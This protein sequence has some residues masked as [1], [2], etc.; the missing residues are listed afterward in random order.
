[1]DTRP[2]S[3][4]QRHPSS[5]VSRTNPPPLPVE[6]AFRGLLQWRKLLISSFLVS[7]LV[8]LAAAHFLQSRK[9]TC[10]GALL[11]SPNEITAPYYRPPLLGNL[12]H[13]INSPAF[14]EQLR[15][16]CKLED[17]L[18]DLRRNVTVELVPSGETLIVRFVRP[19]S[20]E[21]KHVLNTAMLLFVEQTRQISKQALE[22]FVREF[23]SNLDSAQLAVDNANTQLQVF[24]DS[25]EIKNVNS[26]EESATASQ[27]SLAE[28]D[29]ELEMARIEL[30]SATAKRNRLLSMQSQRAEEGDEH[31]KEIAT[32]SLPPVVGDND[33]RQ[34][35]RDQITREQESSSYAVKLNVKERE[36]QRAQKL[37]SQGLISD[38]EM[39]RIDGELSILQAEQNARVSQLQEQLSRIDQK[40]AQRLGDRPGQQAE[41][42]VTLAG[43]VEQPQLLEQSISLLEL[44]ILG[45]EHK[46]KGLA[47][48]FQA[49]QQELAELTQLQK[50]VGPLR[51]AVDIALEDHHRLQNLVDEFVQTYRSDVDDLK[52]VQP[53]MESI[54]GV[55]SNAAKLFA[56]ALIGTFGLLVSPVF[57]YE[58]RKRSGRTLENTSRLLGLPVLANFTK[59]ETPGDAAAF[60]VLRIRR[61]LPDKNS[62][63]LFSGSACRSREI[64]TARA[65]ALAFS[66]TGESVVLVELANEAVQRSASS[67]VSAQLRQREY[68]GAAAGLNSPVKDAEPRPLLVQQSEFVPP[69]GEQNEDLG[70]NPTMGITDYLYG[71]VLDVD[72]IIR[73]SKHPNLSFIRCGAKP[74]SSELLA[75]GRLGDL[76]KRLKTDHSLVVISGVRLDQR[77]RLECFMDHVEGMVL[78]CQEEPF[79]ED[80]VSTVRDLMQMGSAVLGVV[81]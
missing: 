59:E 1:M 34:F 64:A 49:K 19:D 41:G 25:H 5:G 12:I 56:A 71:D 65:A 30:A 6:E 68:A 38:A 4:P 60:L 40:Y 66:R 57:L 35:L 23:Q 81:A 31:D 54:D 2:F 51:Q 24:L 22:H 63:V 13:V 77:L 8:G 29:L 26:L 47:Q 80:A 75:K 62:A 50:E 48:K 27:G 20:A 16:K 72:Q 36:Q 32:G 61:L 3:T 9:Y 11:Y 67:G 44:E 69:P 15:D 37:H 46:T 33:R 79:T 42:Q 52:I 74:L 70:N 43:F 78:C 73:R 53:A 10:E 28:L 55:R 18:S 58:W 39:E 17:S 7:L 14:L 45:A 76:V 21:A